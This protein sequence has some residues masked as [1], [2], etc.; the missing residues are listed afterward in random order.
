MR[1]SRELRVG[2][3]STSADRSGSG[4]PSVLLV[5]HEHD[6][7]RL[8]RL[9]LDG[10]DRFGEVE[11]AESSDAARRRLAEYRFDLVLA[12]VQ[13][14]NHSGLD[15]LAFVEEVSPETVV[16]MTS[17]LDDMERPALERGAAAFLPKHDIG[18]RDLADV[19]IDLVRGCDVR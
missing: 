1:S 19:L 17:A 13:L 10:D 7:R 2:A 5:D 3:G 14:G 4:V 11:E 8:W 6:I 15:L 12:E 16:V 18:V 9:I